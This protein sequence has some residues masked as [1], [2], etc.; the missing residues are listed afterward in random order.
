V[1]I[2]LLAVVILSLFSYTIYREVIYRQEVVITRDKTETGG[3]GTGEAEGGGSETGGSEVIRGMK[4]PPEIHYD[5]LGI[6]L[7]AVVISLAVLFY[8]MSGFLA[9]VRERGNEEFTE[10]VRSGFMLAGGALFVM[11]GFLLTAIAVLV[12]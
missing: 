7:G 5:V 9:V 4:E 1:S 10:L 12:L 6:Y 3:S 2:I 8:W 11:A